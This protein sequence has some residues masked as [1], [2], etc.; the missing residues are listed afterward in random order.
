MGTCEDEIPLLHLLPLLQ[1][2]IGLTETHRKFGVTKS[3]IV[4]FIVLHYRESVTMSEIAKYI[5]SSKEQAT[6]AVAALCDNG[7]VERYED[8]GNRTHVYI[9][10]TGTGKTY[11]EQLIREFRTD[12][13][14]RLASSLDED[15]IQNLNQAVM[16]TVE[17]LSKV[18]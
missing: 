17:I 10:F 18:K 13:F 11:M 1:R 4:I 14:E 7:L 8:P 2:I 3:Q 9:R 5:S 15:D 6:R 12:I 16:T